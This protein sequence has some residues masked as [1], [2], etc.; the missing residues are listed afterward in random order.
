VDYQQKKQHLKYNVGAMIKIRNGYNI[1]HWITN[2]RSNIL[3]NN[4]NID[5]APVCVWSEEGHIAGY[6]ELGTIHARFSLK[7]LLQ[8][9]DME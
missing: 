8:C 5:K 7:N 4:T 2:R 1:R 6:G 3:K 9:K